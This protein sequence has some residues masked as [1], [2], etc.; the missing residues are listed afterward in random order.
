MASAGPE[1]TSTSR[2]YICPVRFRYEAR[3]R[4]EH[5]ERPPQQSQLP[6][7]TLVS[8]RNS[9]GRYMDLCQTQPSQSQETLLLVLVVG[10]YPLSTS[11]ELTVKTLVEM[12]GMRTT[13]VFVIVLFPPNHSEVDK[14]SPQSFSANMLQAGLPYYE[15]KH[16]HGDYCDSK[17][18]STVYDVEEIIFY[19]SNFIFH[20]FRQ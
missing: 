7:V 18:T 17:D 20:C 13:P 3:P 15:L 2:Q 19:S 11:H 14:I 8:G 16:A 4:F 1:S 5:I 9:I 6:D 10:Y 12:M